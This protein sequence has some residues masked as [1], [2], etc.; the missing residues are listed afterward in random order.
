VPSFY[1]MP[2]DGDRS[3]SGVRSALA[4][5]VRCLQCVQHLSLGY[6]RRGR[7]RSLSLADVLGAASDAQESE[8]AAIPR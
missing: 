1:V 5:V 4:G 2:C 7:G 8:D 3:A 6:D